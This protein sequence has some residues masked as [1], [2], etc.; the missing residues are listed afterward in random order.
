MSSNDEV[1]R[2]GKY[3]V[4]FR[5]SV[6]ISPDDFDVAVR[7]M[8]CEESTTVGDIARWFRAHIYRNSDKA[9]VA[10]ITLTETTIVQGRA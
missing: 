3:V 1:V 5:D 9:P 6:Q 8:Q 4:T 7:S 2:T 10:G